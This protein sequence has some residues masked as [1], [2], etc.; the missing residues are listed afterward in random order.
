MAFDYTDWPL[1]A[2]VVTMLASANITPGAGIT[3]DIKT[4]AINSAVNLLVLKT[5]REFKPT[6][7]GT[8]RYYDGTGTGEMIIDDYISITD[9]SFYAL[10][11]QP[12]VAIANYNEVTNTPYAKNRIQI[13]KGPANSPIGYFTRFPQGRSNIQVTATF[14]YGTSIPSAVW[15][16]VLGQAAANLADRIRL[17]S[18]GILTELHDL[19]QDFKWSDKQLGMLAGWRDEFA[20]VTKTFKRPLRDVLKRDTPIL[21]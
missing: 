12:A 20:N 6:S 15:E 3:T 16:A 5:G 18:N 17:T 11:M 9:V 19:D 7:A 10:P 21:I 1:P 14:G 13:F 8:V 4:L 2:D